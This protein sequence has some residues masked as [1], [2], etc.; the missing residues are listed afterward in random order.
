MLDC[1]IP[2]LDVLP[3]LY[4]KFQN[5]K[6]QKET[7]QAFKG[8]PACLAQAKCLLPQAD[9]CLAQARRAA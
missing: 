3:K 9:A 4:Q 8:T 7:Y 6:K 1:F 2:L 5:E